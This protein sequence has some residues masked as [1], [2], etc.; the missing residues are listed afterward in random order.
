MEM[1]KL[2]PKRPRGFA[3][4][5]LDRRQEIAAQGGHA[6]AVPISSPLK[7]PAPPAAAAVEPLRITMSIWRQSVAAARSSERG[8]GSSNMLHVLSGVSTRHFG[9]RRTERSLRSLRPGN[10]RD[11]VIAWPYSQNQREGKQA[12]SRKG[13]RNCPPLVRGS[14]GRQLPTHRH[15]RFLDSG[16][17]SRAGQTPCS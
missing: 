10:S 14:R 11:V 3:L 12:E 2:I 5:S 1:Q 9:I 6:A 16:S 17:D 7:R 13:Q 15:Q 4:L 8:A